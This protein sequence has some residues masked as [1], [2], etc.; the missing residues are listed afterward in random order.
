MKPVYE[1]STRISRYLAWLAGAII[2]FGAALPVAIDVFARALIGRTL[3]ESFEISGYALAIC[4]GLGMGYTVT[5]KANIRVDILT[6]RLPPMLR[7][8]FDLAA[9][10]ALAITALGFA[11]YCFDV[12]QDSARLDARSISTLQVPLILPQSIWWIG[13]AWFASMAILT[14]VY[15]LLRL[16]AGDRRT[17]T[18]LLNAADLLSEMQEGGV[19][20]EGR[21]Q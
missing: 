19:I 16:I 3:L 2:L 13:L 6:R 12:L 5:T 17:A 10:L 15:A 21:R 8:V 4:I 11:W 7:L 1:L 14:F 18:Q 20:G 9:S